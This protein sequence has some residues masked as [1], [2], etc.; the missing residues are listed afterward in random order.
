[1]KSSR[2]S[3]PL[4]VGQ[5]PSRSKHQHQRLPN[6]VT[7][8]LKSFKPTWYKTIATYGSSDLRKSLWQV[9]NTFVPY[10]L[11]WALM[12]HSVQRDYPYWITLALAILAGGMM[13]RIFILFHDCCHGSFF[14]SRWGNTVLGYVSGIFTFTPFEDW[15][16]GHNS[17][18]ATAGDLDRRGIGDIWTMTREEYLAAS[19]RKRLRYRFYR[20][21]F[22]LFGPGA[23]LLFLIIQRFPTKGAGKKERRSV[24]F[25][26]LALLA[27]VAVAG[28]TIGLKTYLLV[29]LPII[30]VGGTFGLLLFYV[31]HQFENV[32]WARHDLWDPM[33]VALDGSSYLKLPKVLQWVTGNIN[34]HHIHH[35]RPNIPNYNLQ[36]CYDEVPAFQEVKPITLWKSFSLLRLGLYDEAQRKMITF[37]S[38][39][40]TPLIGPT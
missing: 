29:Q 7:D 35:V 15:K 2:S 1:M 31:Q 16:Y 10:C 38:L 26:N 34:L 21:P 5:V 39:K 23:A 13:V 27:I 18:H 17:H 14:S 28:F 25:T 20:N 11:L 8:K 33:R 12:L 4:L 30:L 9:L 24:L 22:V 3:E 32:Y 6:A 36:R 40:V 37:R 19:P